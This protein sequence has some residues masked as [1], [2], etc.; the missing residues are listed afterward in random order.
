MSNYIKLYELILLSYGPS[1]CKEVNG[2]L[3]CDNNSFNYD[4]K[5]PLYAKIFGAYTPPVVFKGK[6]YPVENLIKGLY[7]EEIKKLIIDNYNL[8]KNDDKISYLDDILKLF[9][10]AESKFGGKP[11]GYVVVYKSNLYK[12]Q[13]PYQLDKNLRNQVK[14]LYKDT[15]ENESLYWSEVKNLAKDLINKIGKFNSVREA[16]EKISK[17][18]KKLDLPKHSK[19][20]N[21]TIKDDIVLTA[22]LLILEK[23]APKTGLIIGKI[24]VL[25]KAH[26]QLI[27]NALNNNEYVIIALSVAKGK[28]KTFNIRKKFIE[29][30]FKD[31][32]DRIEIIGTQNGFI[33]LIISK[34]IYGLGVK[35]IYA[36]TDRAKT[37]KDQIKKIDRKINIIELKRT[38]DDISATKILNNIDNKKYFE[39]NTPKCMWNF[40]KEIL[41][42]K[43]LFK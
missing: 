24:R 31:E 30:C 34:A 29:H 26:Y 37:Y 25:T 17:E 5:R 20:N 42:N 16:L 12:F 43:G 7:S 3:I 21:P 6:L 33:P 4:N 40:Y 18:V 38:E 36:G 41:K 39:E 35:N 11:E 27:K 13:Q 8:L 32:L 1:K 2:K 23:L 14:M 10:E 22:K 28:D 9:L 15:P 19:K